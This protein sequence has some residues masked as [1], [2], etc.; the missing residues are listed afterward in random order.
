MSEGRIVATE[1]DY[2]KLHKPFTLWLVKKKKK[3]FE[4]L[5]SKKARKY[6]KKFI[7]KWNKGKLS[8]T[9]Y[10]LGSLTAAHGGSINTKHVWNFKMNETEKSAL[11]KTAND[12]SNSTYSLLLEGG[13]KFDQN[14]LFDRSKPERRPQGSNIGPDHRVG[15]SHDERFDKE[16]RE[17][18]E[19]RKRKM[20]KK[21]ARRDVEERMEDLI[22]KKVGKEA[23]LEKKREANKKLNGPRDET[24]MEDYEEFSGGGDESFQRAKAREMQKAKGRE[25]MRLMKDLEKRKRF[26]AY[27][28]EEDKKM[29]AFLQSVNWK[30]SGK[31]QKREDDHEDG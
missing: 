1:D 31:I 22:P 27:Q 8:K 25:E 12:V 16:E 13:E 18:Y 23:L 7:K 10:D 9:Y 28:Q 3:D 20:E 6:F 26:E 11:K 19:Q 5:S 15:D 21:K 29:E 30:R 17:E 4:S 24:G 14:E 2:F